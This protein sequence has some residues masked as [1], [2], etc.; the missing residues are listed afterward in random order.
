MTVDLSAQPDA[1]GNRLLEICEGAN[2]DGQFSGTELK[3][4]GVD[5]TGRRDSESMPTGVL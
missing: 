3:E 5:Q 4:A 2:H 1:I